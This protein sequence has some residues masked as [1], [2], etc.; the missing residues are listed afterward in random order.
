MTS[1]IIPVCVAAVTVLAGCA[2]SAPQYYSL[3][4]PTEKAA[5]RVGR[6]DTTY[7]IS[8]QP[9]VVPEQ[10][11][12]PQIVVSAAPGAEVVPLNAALWAAP[13]EAQI[14]NTLADA[15]TR[16]LNVMDVAQSGG[17]QGMPVWRIYV[18]VKRFDSMY[19]EAVQQD[20]V[21]RMVPQGMPKN[22]KERV[23]TADVRLPVGTGMSALVQGHREA[24]ERIAAVMARALPMSMGRTARQGPEV[25]PEGVTFRGCVG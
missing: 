20:L 4:A 7:A 17:V 23:C 21:W 6:V 8:V 3:Q 11:A 13:L 12:R 5:Q 19:G 9:V 25:A 15:L 14:R 2:G 24:L 10:V 22:L 1:K 16:Q 18:D